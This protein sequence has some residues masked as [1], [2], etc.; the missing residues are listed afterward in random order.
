MTTVGSPVKTPQNHQ[1]HCHGS[2]LASAGGSCL[3]PNFIMDELATILQSFQEG[4]VVTDVW[5]IPAFGTE[6]DT[7]YNIHLGS[8]KVDDLNVFSF[9]EVPDVLMAVAKAAKFIAE[10]RVTEVTEAFA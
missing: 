7:I 10:K 2:A 4:H 3:F 8:T 5:Q 6:E 9:E 1:H